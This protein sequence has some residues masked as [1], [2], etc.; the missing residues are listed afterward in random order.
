MPGIRIVAD[1]ACDL[2]DELVAEHGVTIVPLTIRFGTEELADLGPKEF[3]AKC[4][5][6][7]V[8]PETS[9][10]APG[11]FAE[12][13]GKLAADG[14]DG[15]VCINISSKLSATIQSAQAAAREVADT[16]PVRVIDSLSVSLGQGIQVLAAAR[17]A[18]EGEGGSE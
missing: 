1:S 17:R 2:P 4:R 16:I 7:S 12:A 6:S 5:Q 18:E 15:V 8:L 13:F 10:P 3:W 14:A 11:A 9:A